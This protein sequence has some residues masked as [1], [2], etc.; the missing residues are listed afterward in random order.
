MISIKTDAGNTYKIGSISDINLDEADIEVNGKRFTE[1]DARALGSL[2]A[3]RNG[4]RGGRPRKP[5]AERASVTKAIRLTR[6]ESDRL[7]QAARKNQTT[8]TQIIRQAL[9]QYLATA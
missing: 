9:T 8:E 3:R 4:A 2:I 5:E 7:G 1:A 6:A